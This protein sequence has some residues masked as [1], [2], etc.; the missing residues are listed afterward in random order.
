MHGM[1]KGTGMTCEVKEHEILKGP[2]W[3][4]EGCLNSQ[5]WKITTLETIN[6]ISNLGILEYLSGISE[7]SLDSEEIS[8]YSKQ[9]A[10]NTNDYSNLNQK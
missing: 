8:G 5:N 4:L 3:R 2:W 9:S 1:S 7:T 6:F 10:E